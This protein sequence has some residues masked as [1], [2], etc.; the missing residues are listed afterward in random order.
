MLG[1]VTPSEAEE[2]LARGATLL[3]FFPAEANGGIVMIKALAGP[4]GQTGVK[5]VPT[6]GVDMPLR[7]A[8]KATGISHAH[9][10]TLRKVRPCRPSKR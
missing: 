8:A 7:D 2:T 9:V 6:G 4:Y 3:K 10:K 1:A 5:F